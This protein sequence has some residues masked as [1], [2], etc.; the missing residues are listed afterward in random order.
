MGCRGE[1]NLNP[2][3]RALIYARLSRTN[4]ENEATV[5]YQVMRCMEHVHERGETCEAG[6]IYREGEGLHSGRSLKAR[7]AMQSLIDRIKSGEQIASV[8][9]LE[10]SRTARDTEFA[11]SFLRLLK[12]H[13]VELVSVNDAVDTNT[14]SGKFQYT[15][16]SAFNQQYADFISGKM[17]ESYDRARRAGWVHQRN[18]AIGLRIVGSRQDRHF[19]KSADFPIILKVFKLLA[20]GHTPSEIANELSASV[21]VQGSKTVKLQEYH[22]HGIVA[23][24]AMYKPFIAAETWN[25]ARRRTRER[26]P[27]GRARPVSHPPL[28]LAHIATCADCGRLFTA[29]WDRETTSGVLVAVYRHSIDAICPNRHKVRARK[30]DAQVWVVLDQLV[31]RLANHNLANEVSANLDD[32]PARDLAAE[33]TELEKQLRTAKDHLLHERITPGDF[34]EFAKEVNDK[35]QKLGKEET[36]SAPLSPEDIRLIAESAAGWRM[37]ADKDPREFNLMLRDIF[38]RIAIRRDNT[39][40]IELAPAFR[41]LGLAVA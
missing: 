8:V 24:L 12:S 10:S 38:A 14:A 41:A 21:R 18:P 31:E 20:R 1:R 22:V 33:R 6:D 35:L 11:L 36:P 30:I 17:K 5:D 34:D 40:I 4:A 3:K 26:T 29:T 28:M 16:Q 27:T 15:I 2:V 39:L 37:M 13:K 25:A 23:N 19:E 32:T 9:V 7:P